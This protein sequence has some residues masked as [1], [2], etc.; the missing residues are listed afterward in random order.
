LE[1]AYVIFPEETIDQSY[2]M[3]MSAALNKA[4]AERGVKTGAR[5]LTG[6]ELDDAAIVAEIEKFKPDGLLVIDLLG[7]TTYYNQIVYMTYSATLVIGDRRVWKARIESDPGA[8]SNQ[9]MHMR[10]IAQ[11]LVLKLVKDGYVRGLPGDAE[12]ISQTERR[13]NRK[14]IRAN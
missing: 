13:R 11:Q 2:A 7:G 6:F 3:N 8:I 9:K 4:L 5:V 10:E 12:A 14:N 1:R